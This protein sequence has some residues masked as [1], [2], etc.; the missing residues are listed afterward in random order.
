M[1][2]ITSLVPGD[3][4]KQKDTFAAHIDAL[5][6]IRAYA[7]AVENTNLVTISDPPPDW[8]NTLSTNLT[9]AKQHATVWTTT[10]EPAIV[11]T[12]PQAVITLGSRFGTGVTAILDILTQ[13]KNNPTADQI[14]QIKGHM[15]WIVRHI[16][17]ESTDIATVKTDFTTFQTNSGADLTNLTTG[18]NSIQAAI[19]ADNNDIIKMNGDIAS[20]TADIRA[21]QAAI[22][23]AGIAAG[24]GL[25]VGVA[26]VG[27][28]AAAAGPAAPIVMAIGAFIIVGSIAEAAAT[29]AVY[30]KKIST[31]Q[32][33]MNNDNA[34]LDSDNKQV[35]ALTIMNNSISGLVTK[36]Q[37]M[38][39]SLT[40]IADWWGTVTT[41]MTTVVQDISDA[42][43][44]MSMDDWSDFQSDLQQAQKDWADFVT[45]ATNMQ[46][47]ATTIQNKVIDMRQG[48][49]A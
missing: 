43:D 20:L 5:T 18:N 16:N 48:V 27:L 33:N 45:F 19:L 37:A 42:S 7:L 49:A 1:A 39:Q 41:K 30:E 40:D 9:A 26:M 47:I 28:G 17:D 13:S 10:I 25:F 29:I 23:A 12:I 3:V 34:E 22:T 31:A 4:A 35:A 24:V 46:T 38:G 36:N 14:T 21:D 2:K 32:T 6:Q 44:D 11:S 8:Y 15:S